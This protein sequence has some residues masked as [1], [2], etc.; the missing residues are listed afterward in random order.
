MCNLYYGFIRE[1]YCVGLY[2]TQE[3]IQEKIEKNLNILLVSAIIISIMTILYTLF[4]DN[5]TLCDFSFILSF[6]IM[7]W[8]L[9]EH[10]RKVQT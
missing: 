5:I 6:F 10:K 1:F 4:S 2:L 8:L 3:K 9:I 7:V